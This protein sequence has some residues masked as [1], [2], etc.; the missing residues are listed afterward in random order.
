[1]ADQLNTISE[2]ETI[3]VTFDGG[4]IGASVFKEVEKGV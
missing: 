3:L 4:E 1:L 2:P